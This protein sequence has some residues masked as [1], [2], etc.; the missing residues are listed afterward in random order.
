MTDI[1]AFK[2]RDAANE[3]VRIPLSTPDGKATEHWLLIRSVWCDDFQEAR[4]ELIRQAIADGKTVSAAPEAEQKAIRTDL[5][6]KRRANAA[7][8]L[9]AGWS[10]DI[11]PTEQNKADFLNDAPQILAWVE[12]IAEEDKRFFG[13][14]SGSS[15]NG[16]KQS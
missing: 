13:K 11:E 6:R 8:S 3:G 14:E 2:I 5:D 12:R 16:E 1:S 10:F 7:A 9:V 4:S 15:L